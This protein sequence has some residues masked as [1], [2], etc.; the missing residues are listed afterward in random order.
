MTDELNIFQII[1]ESKTLRAH[2]FAQFKQI[3]KETGEIL[4]PPISA[5]RIVGIFLQQG[6]WS[7]VMYN[8][9]FDMNEGFHI[10][11][12]KFGG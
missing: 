5:Q 6:Y 2:W 8:I 9:H 10:E 3:I 11:E 12:R 4:I 1:K 7:G